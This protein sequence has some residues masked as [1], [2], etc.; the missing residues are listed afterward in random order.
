MNRRQ[1]KAICR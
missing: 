1:R